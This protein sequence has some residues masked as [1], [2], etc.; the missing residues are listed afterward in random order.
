MVNIDIYISSFK[1]DLQI[2]KESEP[3]DQLENKLLFTIV[4]VKMAVFYVTE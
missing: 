3:E 4:A 1:M 2:Y